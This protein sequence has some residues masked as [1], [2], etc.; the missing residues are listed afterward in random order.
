LRI[1][2]SDLEND[3]LKKAQIFGPPSLL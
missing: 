1:A 2:N 3:G